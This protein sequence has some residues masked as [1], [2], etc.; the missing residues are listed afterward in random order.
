MGKRPDAYIMM[1]IEASGVR[2]GY[3]DLIQFGAVAVSGTDFEFQVPFP[4]YRAIPEAPPNLVAPY[5]KNTPDPGAMKVNGLDWN[6]VCAHGEAPES[7]INRFHDWVVAFKAQSGADKIVLTG[8]GLVFDW[9]FLKLLYNAFRDD[10]PCHYSGLDFKS[11]YG[12]M[13]GLH[14]TQASMTD[15][16]EQFGIGPNRHAHDAQS[17]AEYQLEFMLR[18]FRNSGLVGAPKPPEAIPPAGSGK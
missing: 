13:R 6:M 14:Y 9:S 10:W 17:D 7:F 12:G 5:F 16:R 4:V 3:H 18:A 2:L 15:M 8:H 11:W 1:D